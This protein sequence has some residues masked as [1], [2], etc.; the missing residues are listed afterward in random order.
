M[1]SPFYNLFLPRPRP[2]FSQALSVNVYPG[3]RHIQLRLDHVTRNK[4]AAR[5]EA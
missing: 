4:L 2:A 5:N 1:Q 3:E